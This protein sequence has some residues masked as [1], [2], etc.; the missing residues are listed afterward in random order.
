MHVHETAGHPAGLSLA[1]VLAAIRQAARGETLCVRDIFE[2][3]GERSFAT[4]LLIPA[5]LLV[6]PLSGIPGTP[7]I[8]ALVVMLIVVQ[9]IAGRDHLW[10]PDVLMRRRL[11]SSRVLKALEWL[12]RPARVFDRNAAARL[13]FLTRGPFALAALLTILLIA[14]SWPFLELLPFVTSIGAFAV[15]LFAFGLMTRDG[16][17]VAVGF[18]LVGGLATLLARLI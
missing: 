5:L 13:S 8:G 1:S 6:S 17:W 14:A 7:T 16:A 15:S 2:E 4:A 11:R 18:L 9:W 3:I 12:D 10:L